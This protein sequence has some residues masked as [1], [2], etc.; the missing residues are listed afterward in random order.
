MLGHASNSAP[1]TTASHAQP[2]IS[3]PAIRIINVVTSSPYTKNSRKN[4]IRKKT[5]GFVKVDT[6]QVAVW[7][8]RK[9]VRRSATYNF[10][11]P[12]IESELVEKLRECV[13]IHPIIYYLKSE[14]TYDVIS[15]VGK[16]VQKLFKTSARELSAYNEVENS[17]DQDITELMEK[18][19]I[20]CDNGGVIASPLIV[21]L[22]LCVLKNYGGV[23][24]ITEKHS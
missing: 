13:R 11:L 10:F 12:S 6:N 4:I 21:G 17:V 23:L 24:S 8:F 5:P 3:S 16:T 19:K 22:F 20:F 15:N 2:A 9:N 1:L 18:V 14:A 7:Y